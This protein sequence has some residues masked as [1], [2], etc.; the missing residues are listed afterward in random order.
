[1]D[2]ESPMLIQ[3]PNRLVGLLVCAS[4]AF[5][6]KFFCLSVDVVIHSSPPIQVAGAL[7][8]LVAF[9]PTPFDFDRQSFR[10]I[11]NFLKVIETRLINLQGLVAAQGRLAVE[12]NSN[13]FRGNVKLL[14]QNHHSSEHTDTT[15]E[16][17]VAC[18]LI[19]SGPVYVV[20]LV[21]AF[22]VC[23]LSGSHRK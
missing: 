15:S 5:F 13:S 22:L 4:G 23:I 20:R 21:K 3:E 8:L 6:Q 16:F 19:V 17:A 18:R 14:H 9:H 12:S 11:S 10:A 1:M 7:F 2:L